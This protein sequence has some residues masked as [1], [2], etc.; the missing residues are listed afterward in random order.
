MYVS[1]VYVQRSLFLLL[2]SFVSGFLI[3]TR[4]GGTYSRWSS[5]PYYLL[6]DEKGK[7]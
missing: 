6:A 3:A 4:T 2:L 7:R 5:R 1:G